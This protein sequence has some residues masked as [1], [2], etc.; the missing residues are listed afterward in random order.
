[1]MGKAMPRCPPPRQSPSGVFGPM[2][3]AARV[4]S[5]TERKR[6]SGV[7]TKQECGGRDKRD[8]DAR[9]RDPASPRQ[10]GLVRGLGGLHR[11][12]GAAF[13]GVSEGVRPG[14]PGAPAE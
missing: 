6:C 1:M 3:R 10:R 5:V 13:P 2:R 12:W 9:R 7:P 11:S 14:G 8:G 4:S